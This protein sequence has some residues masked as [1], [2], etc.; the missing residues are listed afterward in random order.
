MNWAD[1]A[2]K[3]V[4]LTCVGVTRNPPS[5]PNTEELVYY[6]VGVVY[7]FIQSRK[8]KGELRRKLIEV[9]FPFVLGVTK[10]AGVIDADGRQLLHRLKDED[11]WLG[12]GGIQKRENLEKKI[13]EKQV[14]SEIARVKAE[15]ERLAS[16]KTN[17]DRS[18]VGIYDPDPSVVEANRRRREEMEKPEDEQSLDPRIGV[19]YRNKGESK[20]STSWFGWLN[21]NTGEH[22]QVEA[23]TKE[24]K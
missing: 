6:G 3:A 23:Q 7:M 24:V 12:A 13:E 20:S 15:E 1:T 14:A 11:S 4:V 22:K 17:T 21:W 2:H 18:R 8:N 10:Q 19:F 9:P 16:E 5:I